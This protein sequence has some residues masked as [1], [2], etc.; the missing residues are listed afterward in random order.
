MIV[1]YPKIP[2]LP[3]SLADNSDTKIARTENFAQMT[4]VVVTEKLDGECTTLYT[5]IV[6]ARSCNG[7]V[8][9]WMKAYHAKFKH[10]IPY[11]YRIV[12]ENVYAKHSIFYDSLDTYFYVFAVFKDSLCLSWED[13]VNFCKQLQL[14]MVPVLYM[15]NWEISNVMKIHDQCFTGKSR[16]GDEQEGYVV[17]NFDGWFMTEHHQNIAKFVRPNHVK[18]THWKYREMIPNELNGNKKKLGQWAVG[19]Q[20]RLL[21]PPPNDDHHRVLDIHHNS[22]Q[23]IWMDGLFHVKQITCA[24]DS[25]R[26]MG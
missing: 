10:L 24:I 5:D 14:H 7:D 12:G 13:T 17:R 15:G 26:F 3:W 22:R 4:K 8:D 6:H 18:G 16:F 20:E 11:G 21:L 9:S 2:H 25:E 19:K 23:K 1:K